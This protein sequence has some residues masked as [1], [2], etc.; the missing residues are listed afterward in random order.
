MTVPSKKAQQQQQIIERRRAVAELR[1]S[2]VRKQRDIAEKLGVGLGTINRDFAALDEEWRERAAADIAIEKSIDLDRIDQMI[3]ALW[4]AAVGG[5]AAA[6]DRV[7]VLI[8]Q[9]AKLLGTEA[10]KRSE[11]SAPDGGPLTIVISE[12]GDGPA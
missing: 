1:L 5:L 8:N 12:R 7:V 4:P 11:V 10:P 6:I 3:I 9:R 2:G